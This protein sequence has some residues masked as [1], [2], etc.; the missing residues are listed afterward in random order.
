MIYDICMSICRT[1]FWFKP[2]D[3]GYFLI[4]LDNA[5]G[6]SEFQCKKISSSATTSGP[7]FPSC[8]LLSCCWLK[9]VHLRYGCWTKPSRLRD[10]WPP[11]T[12]KARILRSLYT[13]EWLETF[14]CVNNRERMGQ[15]F[16]TASVIL[17]QPT[18]LVAGNMSATP[19]ATEDASGG[20]YLG[21]Q[22]HST[23]CIIH[24]MYIT[25][26]IPHVYIHFLD[27]CALDTCACM[28][29]DPFRWTSFGSA[30][31]ARALPTSCWQL[32]TSA[33]KRSVAKK[34]I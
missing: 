10:R 12:H 23:Q 33:M 15:C 28:S 29:Y 11:P 20:S 3:S 19:W 25:Y 18:R 7:V 13:W 9:R 2:L 16:A 17:Q 26:N 5:K 6:V 27:T 30:M 21:M 22:I 32:S 14:P 8:P 24:I 4:C 34:S 31:F 1:C